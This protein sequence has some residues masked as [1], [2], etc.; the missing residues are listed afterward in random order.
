MENYQRP[1]R[2]ELPKKSSA[3]KYASMFMAL[4]YL[5]IGVYIF[6]SGPEQLRI[7]Q[8]SKYIF[9]AMLFFY[10]LFRFVRSYQ[11]YYKKPTRRDEE[12]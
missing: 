11:L 2:P 8:N 10:G 1:A 7:S 4:V 9:G 6:F 3:L 12:V 5:A